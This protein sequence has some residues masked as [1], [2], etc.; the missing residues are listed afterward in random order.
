MRIRWFWWVLAVLPAFVGFVSLSL[1]VGDFRSSGLVT[2]ISLS[3]GLMAILLLLRR[4]WGGKQGV[5]RWISA[6]P[7]LM[8]GLVGLLG[9]AISS[10]EFLEA[11]GLFI[12][13][14]D[15]GPRA[16]VSFD[17]SYVLVGDDTN[18][19]FVWFSAD[20]ATWK[21]VDDPIFDDLDELRDVIAVEGG[22]I[23]VGSDGR[24]EA[25]ILVSADGLVWSEAARFGNVEDGTV[26]RAISQTDTGFDVITSTVG[27]DVEFYRSTNISVWTVVQPAGVFDDGES[28]SDI[29]CNAERCVGVGDHDA[30][31]RS[32]LQADAGVA[33]VNTTGDRYDLV[34]HDFQSVGL[35][36]IAWAESGFLTVGDTSTGEGVAW[37]SQNGQQWTPVTGPFNEMTIDGAA[38]IDGSYVIFGANPTT[39]ELLTWTSDTGNQWDQE[40][41]SND[42][43]EG[44]QIRAISHQ[45]D[46]RT[47]IGIASDTLHTII[48]TSANNQPWQHTATL[49]TTQN[50]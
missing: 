5:S 2:G 42:L 28:G 34:D 10:S 6:I 16:V 7:G 50:G 36:A 44:S 47:A 17:D 35:T 13:V 33:W 3:L 43:P 39:N 24:G 26:G 12:D 14:D 1:G 27:N 49:E 32:D 8:L 38:V 30:T 37:Q 31:Y 29:T 41:I 40:T 15:A 45:N 19:G 20:G 22:L 48:W 18:G 21:P 4:P 9:L 46:T 25:V 11:R 23:A